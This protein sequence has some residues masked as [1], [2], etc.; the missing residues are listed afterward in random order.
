MPLRPSLMLNAWLV[1]ICTGTGA[2][3]V[4]YL[5]LPLAVLCCAIAVWR[6]WNAV[7]LHGLRSSPHSIVGL[8]CSGNGL[9][10][11]FASGRWQEG[12]ATAG[13]LVT[14]FLTLVCWQES[15]EGSKTHYLVILP[16]G[17]DGDDYRRLRMHLRWRDIK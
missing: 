12:H 13:S 14:R 10:C 1:V 3:V 8:K 7:R 9:A 4:I 5:P 15:A 2:L 17:I 16:D 11:L 6:T